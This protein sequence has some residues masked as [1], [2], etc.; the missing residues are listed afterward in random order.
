MEITFPFG[1]TAKNAFERLEM[2]NPFVVE[3]PMTESAVAGVVVPM[4]TLPFG[5]ILNPTV[6]VELKETNGD[7]SEPFNAV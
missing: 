7:V 2:F 5:N 6:E 3:V 1:S 4:P